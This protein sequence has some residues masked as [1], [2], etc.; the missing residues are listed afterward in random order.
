VSDSENDLYIMKFGKEKAKAWPR[1]DHGFEHKKAK[2]RKCLRRMKDHMAELK[3]RHQV[4]MGPAAGEIIN[5]DNEEDFS[6]LKWLNTQDGK[7]Y[8]RGRAAT[9]VGGQYYQQTN[10][11]QVAEGVALAVFGP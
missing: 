2:I 10:N 7:A 8:V 1:S 3:R 11:E 5:S 4:F 9:I 6:W